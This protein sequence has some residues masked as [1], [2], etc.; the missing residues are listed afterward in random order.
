MRSSGCLPAASCSVCWRPSATCACHRNWP[1]WTNL[2]VSFS[3]TLAMCSTIVMRWRCSLPSWHSDQHT[4][5]QYHPQCQFIQ[6]TA[7]HHPLQGQVFPLLRTLSKQGETYV[8]IQLPSGATQQVPERWTDQCPALPSPQVVPL[9]SM[10][11]VRSLLDILKQLQDRPDH[12]EVI[13]GSSPT[14]VAHVFSP[15]PARPDRAAGRTAASSSSRP[16]HR[17]NS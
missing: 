8:V 12:E 5:D 13:D 4:T 11:S 3:M 1:S 16:T 15:G 2:P 17:R 14:H 10:T 9:W 6:V 7:P